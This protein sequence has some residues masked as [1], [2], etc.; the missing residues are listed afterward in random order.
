MEGK[1]THE[2]AQLHLQVYEQRREAPFH[3]SVGA[4][5]E[6][7]DHQLWLEGAKL[8]AKGHDLDAEGDKLRAQRGL[9]LVKI[10]KLLQQGD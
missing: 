6:R 10:D 3:S 5:L 2:Q 8:R 9:T 7:L 4:A 1:P